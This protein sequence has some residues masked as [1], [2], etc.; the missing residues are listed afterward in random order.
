MPSDDP[1]SS[2]AH[3]RIADLWVQAWNQRNADRLAAL[4]EAN[5]EFVKVTDLW[6]HDRE[7][8]RR[9]HAYG[10]HT[11][12]GQSPFRWWSGACSGSW[13]GLRPPQPPR[14]SMPRWRRTGEWW[15]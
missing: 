3:K 11:I 10:L 15:R 14:R 5:A 13:A 8:I 2:F 9:V 7:S 12:F 6:W 1:Y 4:F